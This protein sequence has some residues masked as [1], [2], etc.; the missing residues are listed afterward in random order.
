MK[1]GKINLELYKAQVEERK[2]WGACLY[3]WEK[4]IN[5]S[6]ESEIKVKYDTIKETKLKEL[7]IWTFC[8]YKCCG[9]NVIHVT[10]PH[11]DT[12]QGTTLKNYVL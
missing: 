3:F 5:K 6:L 11:L 12:Q 7:N 4:V 2:Q 9:G 10:C 8:L 1:K